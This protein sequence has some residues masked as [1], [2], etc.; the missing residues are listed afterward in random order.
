M[1]HVQIKQWLVAALTASSVSAIALACSLDDS[2]PTHLDCTGPDCLAE[3]ITLSEGSAA[4]EL[5]DVDTSA[6]PRAVRPLSPGGAWAVGVGGTV[7]GWDGWAWTPSESGTKENLNAVW[8]SAPN[9]VWAVGKNVAVIRWDGNRWSAASAVPPVPGTTSLRTVWGAGPKDIYMA[10]DSCTGDSSCTESLILH[11]DGSTFTTQTQ[12]TRIYSIWGSGPKDV[13]ASGASGTMYHYDGTTWSDSATG[14]KEHLPALWGTSPNDVWA[15]GGFSPGVVIHFDGTQWTKTSFADKG[16]AAIWA[17]SPSDVWAVGNERTGSDPT[18]APHAVGR[19]MH[20]D[21]MAWSPFA[22]ATADILGGI[23]GA[24]STDIWSVGYEGIF[25]WNGSEW[26]STVSLDTV[27]LDVFA[28]PAAA[29]VA[30][31]G[32]VITKTPAP[33]TF[34][35]SASFRTGQP[36]DPEWTDEKNLCRPGFCLSVCSRD[37]KCA[38]KSKC[39]GSVRDGA[40]MGTTHFTVAFD[41]DNAYVPDFFVAVTPVSAPGCPGTEPALLAAGDPSVIAGRAVTVA[42]GYSVLS[43][44]AG[45]GSGSDSGSGTCPDGWYG[46]V[47]SCLPLG[48]GGSCECGD[49]PTNR[50][51][52]RSEFQQIGSTLPAACLP[53][54]NTGC[55]ATDNSGNLAHPCCPG[56]SCVA[57]A[58]CGV[59]GPS[60]CMTK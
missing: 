10:G 47:R 30:A 38:G 55:L 7:L 12:K 24:S 8:G 40:R 1:K 52:T 16:P 27:L 54:D 22:I 26:Q 25:H 43:M 6:L 46:S 19:A 9:D 39:T 5:V 13:W 4:L 37:M 18:P 11:W 33:I 53:L 28:F 17:T 3:H 58:S 31:G 49:S 44:P 50:C 20:W 35:G 57:G 21:G 14:V 41:I 42:G 48:A 36:L 45:S 59:Q 15:G 23:S 2:F 60:V 51:I 29:P 34:P 56:L 32:P